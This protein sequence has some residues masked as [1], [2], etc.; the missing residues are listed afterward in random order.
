MNKFELQLQTKRLILRRPTVQDAQAIFSSYPTQKEVTQSVSAPAQEEVT[1]S[2]LQSAFFPP[3]NSI[4]DTLN[5]IQWSNT[6]WE[7]KVGYIF[8][9]CSKDDGG[10]VIGGVG[11]SLTGLENDNDDG[12]LVHD[13]SEESKSKLLPAGEARV[14]YYVT[15]EQWGKGYATEAVQKMIEF[16]A[17]A[18]ESEMS[19][20]KLVA[21]VHPDNLASIRVLEKCGFQEDK[22]VGEMLVALPDSGKVKARLVGFGRSL[23][24]SDPPPTLTWED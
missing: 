12:R 14:G 15:N 24:L 19:I 23:S 18:G 9:V 3:P 2:A 7:K 8:I 20:T 10:R 5:F 11:L 13:E 21:R 17:A 16:A 22:M 1:R 6:Q 4:E